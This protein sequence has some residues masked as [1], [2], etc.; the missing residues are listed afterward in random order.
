MTPKEKKAAEILT[1]PQ[2]LPVTLLIVVSDILGPEW[3]QYDPETVQLE[4][5]ESLN[6]QIRP[7]NFNKLMAAAQIVQG[8]DFYTDLPTF[9]DLCNALY[10]GTFNPGSFDPADAIEMACGIT[11][12]ML[13][14]PPEDLENPFSDA[15][16]QYAAATIKDE[17]INT[18]PDIRQ[19]FWGK[20]AP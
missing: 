10:N 5:E 14:W 18:P 8:D 15:I 12:A 13:L 16:V 3:L 17:G 4:I 11:D 2:S 6:T 9:I 1:D 20:N 19:W 7:S